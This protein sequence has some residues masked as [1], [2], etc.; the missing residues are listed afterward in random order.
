MEPCDYD[1]NNREKRNYDLLSKRYAAMD[2]SEF[3]KFVSWIREEFEWSND[4]IQ[5]AQHDYFPI[6]NKF[7]EWNSIK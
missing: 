4:D 6:L 5:E 2:Y 1:N 3:L 7:L